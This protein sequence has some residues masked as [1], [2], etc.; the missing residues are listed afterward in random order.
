[1]FRL[2]FYYF[3]G[4][5]IQFGLRVCRYLR[6]RYLTQLD[7]IIKPKSPVHLIDDDCRSVSLDTIEA[8]SEPAEEVDDLEELS[9]KFVGEVDLPQSAWPVTRGIQCALT[10]IYRQGAIV[11]GVEPSLRTFPHSIPRG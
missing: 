8:C 7:H 10:N 6:A 4:C 5:A 11:E 1:V 9:K 2:H 3:D